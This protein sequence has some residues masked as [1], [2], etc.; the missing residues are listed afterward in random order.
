VE[1]SKT[2]LTID[3]LAERFELRPRT[4]HFYIAQGLLPSPGTRGRSV[5][6]G[7][8][9]QL[10]LEVIRQLTRRH[11]PLAE[12]KERLR[13]LSTEELRR[14]VEE[15]RRQTEGLE[16]ARGDPSPQGYIAALLEQARLAPSE[17]RATAPSRSAASEAREDS[18]QVPGRIPHAARS[19]RTRSEPD[20][21]RRRAQAWRRWEIAPGVELHASN[22]GER[23]YGTLIKRLLQVADEHEEGQGNGK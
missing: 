14:L 18:G 4:I 23:R 19:W 10:R 21:S 7:E 17:A 13:G 2:G 5:R 15:E 6:Y 11:V 20:A 9:H 16:R 12:I 3:E 8:E 22:E 1:T